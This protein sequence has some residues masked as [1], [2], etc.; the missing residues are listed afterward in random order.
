MSDDFED[1]RHSL[2]RT[3]DEFRPEL[4]PAALAESGR[5]KRSR[6]N[7][8]AGLA[9]AGA[10]AVAAVMMVPSL[11]PAPAVVPAIP[12]PAATASATPTTPATSAPPQA[13]QK[14]PAIT[15]TVDTSGWKTFTSREYPVTFSYPGNWT[16]DRSANHKLDGC[17][18]VNC[19]LFVNP[20]K[21]TKA[22]PLELIRNGFAKDDTTGGGVEDQSTVNVLGAVPDV[23]AWAGSA[24]SDQSQLLVASAPSGY[25]GDDY[26][27]AT[28][29]LSM[30]VSVG[31]AN[32]WPAHPEGVFLFS[33]NI[34]NIGG[35]ND[36]AGR[37]TVVAILASTR[38]NPDFT[39]TL[40][41]DNGS[42]DPV[43][44]VFEPMTAPTFGGVKP[45]AS[46]KTFTSK[47]GNVSVRYPRT[48]KAIDQKDGVTWLKAPSGYI[49]DLL[50]NSAA[51][52]CDGGSDGRWQ[53]LGEAAIT[54]GPDS[55]GTGPVLVV[56]YP[57]GDFPA[58]IELMQR[59]TKK[60]C[61]Q[62][63]L[64]FGGQDVYLGSADNS[65]NPTQKELETAAAIVASATRLR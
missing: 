51:E 8:V 44:P 39:P 56:W 45:D 15:S 27:L 40:T 42:G 20:P 23:T 1:L 25:D 26:F 6:R 10:L 60:G 5:R 55:M 35:S 4:D 28:E 30:R 36:K 32:S 54:A 17:D 2:K 9:G 48:W 34:G 38:P 62:R 21:G 52:T 64:D 24:G 41:A 22:A 46:W 59:S 49:I 3:A 13:G 7:L 65:A 50:T 63:A 31:E 19:V 61:Y 14:Y 53:V 47:A 57:G 12:A 16:L 37:D 29:N 58:Q 43:T 33:T 11:L 18:S